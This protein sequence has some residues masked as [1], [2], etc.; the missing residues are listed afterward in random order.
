M[1]ERTLQGG[2]T[3]VPAPSLAENSSYAKSSY[4]LVS[5]RRICLELVIHMQ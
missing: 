3:G 4:W 1:L 5:P 2:E